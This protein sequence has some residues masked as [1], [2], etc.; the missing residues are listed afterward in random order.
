MELCRIKC[1]SYGIVQALYGIVLHTIW[2][3]HKPPKIPMQLCIVPL[4]C[5]TY[6]RAA[7]SRGNFHCLGRLKGHMRPC[8]SPSPSISTGGGLHDNDGQQH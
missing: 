6:I 4:N 5:T 2:N 7:Y 8:S 1:A 3:L